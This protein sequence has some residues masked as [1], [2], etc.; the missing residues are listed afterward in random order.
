MKGGG[1]EGGE[2]E[3]VHVE[4]YSTLGNYT[5]LLGTLFPFLLWILIL[6]I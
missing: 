1:L 6:C 4:Y 3:K 5:T 2:K